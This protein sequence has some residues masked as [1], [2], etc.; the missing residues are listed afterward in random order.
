[1]MLAR[2]FFWP[3]QKKDKRLR[4]PRRGWGRTTDKEK[5]TLRALSTFFST[6]SD[7]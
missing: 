7:V 6:Q 1:M 2:S 4:N 3:K 5:T